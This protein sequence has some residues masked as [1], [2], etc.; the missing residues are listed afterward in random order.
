YLMSDIFQR[1]INP[2]DAEVKREIERF[3]TR[4]AQVAFENY[5]NGL[6]DWVDE[7]N[8]NI[9]LRPLELL[10]VLGTGAI[11]HFTLFD[12]YR[13]VRLFLQSF[14]PTQI[15]QFQL[16]NLSALQTL[17]GNF[18]VNAGTAIF[19]DVDPTSSQVRSLITIMDNNNS[20]PLVKMLQKGRET[21]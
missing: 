18:G 12:N 13:S 9:A 3:V 21:S 11:P 19:E 1:E 15:P 4:E 5:V 2:T 7:V 17:F 6:N 16:N 8:A 10:A 20:N 14:S